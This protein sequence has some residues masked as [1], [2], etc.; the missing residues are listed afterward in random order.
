MNITY[1]DSTYRLPDDA[2]SIQPFAKDDDPAYLELNIAGGAKFTLFNPGLWTDVA[3]AMS[4]QLTPDGISYNKAAPGYVRS[5][6]NCT[7]D[8]MFRSWRLM[9]YNTKLNT[10]PLEQKYIYLRLSPSTGYAMVVFSAV[11]H[12]PLEWV[13]MGGVEKEGYGV[14]VRVNSDI[15]DGSAISFEV[16][17]TLV[18]LRYV[19]IRIGTLGAVEEGATTR[20]V[21]IDCGCLGADATMV[22]RNAP[23]VLRASSIYQEPLHLDLTNAEFLGTSIVPGVGRIG[24][25]GDI[26]SL[27]QQVDMYRYELSPLTDSGNMISHR[28]IYSPTP[29][30][31]RY[32]LTLVLPSYIEHLGL[33]YYCAAFVPLGNKIRFETREDD[34][35]IT[36]YPSE[37][38]FD[39]AL[40]KRFAVTEYPIQ[41]MATPDGWTFV[42]GLEHI[43]DIVWEAEPLPTVEL[44]QYPEWDVDR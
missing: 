9:G 42:S 26:G 10:N 37:D 38:G 30:G 6:L 17:E 3:K 41:L 34:A 43:T 5:L 29:N 1:T 33:T 14:K 32:D 7:S 35:L 20:E 27:G 24:S 21:S 39:R 11:E 40:I 8:G 13:I 19:W 12:S 18:D 36:P 23:N 15:V 28:T 2:I 31:N 16:A 22:R 4:L 25:I 44:P